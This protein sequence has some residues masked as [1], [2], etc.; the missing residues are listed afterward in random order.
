MDNAGEEDA[1]RSR[2][3]A[4][5]KHTSSPMK[6]FVPTA[7]EQSTAGTSTPPGGVLNA[8]NRNRI[9]E[10]AQQVNAQKNNALLAE[11]HAGRVAR[12]AAQNASAQPDASATTVRNLPT[13]PISVLT[14]NVWFEEE[15]ALE[16]R[17][18]AIGDV[19]VET[20]F[21]TVICLQEVTDSIFALLSSAPWMKQ[22]EACPAGGQAY[23]TALLYRRD[24]VTGAQPA[25]LHR[26]PGSCMGRGRQEVT[27]SFGDKS[28]RFVTSHLESPCGW[29]Q[30][31]A[32]QRLIQCKTTL[33]AL[34]AAGEGNVIF[35]GDLN[36]LPADGPLPLTDGWVDAWSELHSEEAGYT[37]DGKQNPMLTTKHR[38]RLDRVLA[39]LADWK[40]GSIEIVG[41]EAIPGVTRTVKIRGM[42]KE[43]PVLPSDHFGLFFT[44]Q[45]C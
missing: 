7:S 15:V 1:A 23:Y 28:C 40:P 42:P 10:H 45:P 18:A 31:M 43:L 36:W 30:P 2:I 13:P 27:L 39:K 17:M 32:E 16:E 8:A 25:C 11:L 6:P 9:M 3:M 24:A 21:P 22:Y 26:F 29:N 19:I 38:T 5:A 33:A 37:Y 34:D 14:Y 44:M 41:T 20:G 4:F 35:A 12:Q